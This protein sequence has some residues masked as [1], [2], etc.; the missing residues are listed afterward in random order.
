MGKKIVGLYGLL[1][2]LSFAI[3]SVSCFN[4]WYQQVFKTLGF[5][6][7]FKLEVSLVSAHIPGDS[8]IFCGLVKKIWTEIPPRCSDI[9]E[10]TPLQD[11]A[12]D[13]CAP[14]VYS[15]W[16]VPC[17]AFNTAYIL[18]IIVILVY[19]LN[20]LFIGTCFYLL[21]YYVSSKS[22]KPVYRYWAAVLHAVGT[23][24][25]AVACIFYTIFGMMR[26]NAL[27]GTG[28]PGFFEASQSVGMTPGYFL[29]WIGVIIQYVALGLHVCMQ[30]SGEETEEHR[31]YKDLLREQQQ[32]GAIEAQMQGQM[33]PQEYPTAES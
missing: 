18:G 22:H 16:P 14:L 23:T 24:M 25:M 10:P 12:A 7:V 21:Y 9:K 27:G 2:L 28:I 1:C 6:T 29:V 17:Q 20:I 13:W 15:V 33:P 8:V 30:V 4:K 19:S 11:L 26:L 3:I 32:Y 5:K 31:M